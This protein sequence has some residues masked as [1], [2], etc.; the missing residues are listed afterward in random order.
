MLLG[1]KLA[2]ITACGVISVMAE[3]MVDAAGVEASVHSCV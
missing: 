3:F 1:L 2:Y